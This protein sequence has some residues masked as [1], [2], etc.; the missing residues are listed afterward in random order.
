[1]MGVDEWTPKRPDA[2]AAAALADLV[3]G[4]LGCEA[5]DEAE[6]R[7]LTGVEPN[8]SIKVNTDSSSSRRISSFS[9]LFPMIDD[10]AAAEDAV[11]GA[12]SAN[13]ASAGAVS[14]PIPAT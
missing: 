10:S 4:E 1:M 7:C 14:A 9:G 3:M 2:D 11:E 5:I 13:M 6:F 8:P 12:A